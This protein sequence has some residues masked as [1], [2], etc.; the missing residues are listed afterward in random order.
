LCRTILCQAFDDCSGLHSCFRLLDSFSGLLNR[1]VIQHDFEKKYFSLLQTYS[2]DLDDVHAIYL[3]F[4]DNPP[5]HYNMAPVTGA[6]AWAHELKE[7]IGRSMEK[8]KTVRYSAN[9]FF[10]IFQFFYVI[11]ESQ[12]HEH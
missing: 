5:I 12:R 3:K 10:P 6:V 1:Q 11:V 4:K 2:Q 8:L 7:R 9:L